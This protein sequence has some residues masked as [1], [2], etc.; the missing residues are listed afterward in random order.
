MEYKAW[1]DGTSS[2]RSLAFSPTVSRCLNRSRASAVD[3]EIGSWSEAAPILEKA[4][5]SLTLADEAVIQRLLAKNDKLLRIVR[6]RRVTGRTGLFAYLPLNDRGLAALLTSEF[7]GKSPDPSWICASGDRPQAVYIWLAY[8]PGMLASALSEIA[9]EFQLVSE[10]ACTVFSRAA[11]PGS[12]RVHNTMGFLPA[13]QFY[14]ECNPELLVAFAE[15]SPAS[16]RPESRVYVARQLDD[17]MK[18]MAVRAATYLA[19]QFCTFDEEFDGNDF[20]ATHFLGT[21]DGDAAG[22]IRVRFFAGFAKI[23]RL[24][25]RVEYRNSRLAYELVRAAIHHCRMKGYRTLYGHSRLDLTRFWRI[26]GFRE[27]GDRESFSF[28]NVRYV[29]MLLE[30][31]PSEQA[32][33]LTAA[34]MVLIRPEGAWDRPGPLDRSPSEADPRRRALLQRRT[35]TVLE[36]N[37][38]I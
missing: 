8:M 35:R 14:P 16:A 5:Q 1:A 30:T 17:M 23:E 25:V 2:F 15:K 24:A 26:F 38:A 11:N 27:R 6:C 34:P 9:K 36:T 13:K 22:C 37:I 7:D 29:E 31:E 10:Q 28:A 18:I 32:V 19:E 4:R 3:F 12:R 33:D 20:C 21:I